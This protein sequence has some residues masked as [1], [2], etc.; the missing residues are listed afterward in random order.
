MTPT[1]LYTS[2]GGL[3]NEVLLRVLDEIEEQTDI[4]E[5]ESIR[6]NK[7]CKMLHNLESLFDGS[8]V[9]RDSLS[10]P[11]DLS[12]RVSL[13]T[14][15]RTDVSGPRSAGVVQVRLPERVARGVDGRHPLPL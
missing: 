13:T 10:P 5:D 3:I 1:A 4:S 2:L 14:L 9:R 12:S 15:S 6:L 8:E 11:L 7:L